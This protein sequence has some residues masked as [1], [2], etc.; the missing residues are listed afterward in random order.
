MKTM[1]MTAVLLGLFVIAGCG[2]TPKLEIETFEVN[3][4]DQ[5]RL[6]QLIEPYIFYG[7]EGTDG[8]Y[9]LSGN[10]LTVRETPDN[11]ARIT[12]VLRMYDVRKP[13]IMLHID[14][15][16][17]D[18]GDIDPSIQDIADRLRELF[19]F[20][21]YTKV[22]GGI[23]SVTE[24][25]S[26]EQTMGASSESERGSFHFSARFGRLADE[27]GQWTLFAESLDLRRRDGTTI[28]TSA[29][30]RTGQTTLVGTSLEGPGAKA[31][32]LAVRPEI[33]E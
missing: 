13:E 28:S 16:E 12:D 32:I 25:G 10:I 21:G 30:L 5:H 17:A 19:R 27:D 3:N 2:R 14:I 9:T 20:T 26:V 18:G 15:I 23:I 11:L 31:V 24:G 8:M 33:H 1:R 6:S 29:L 7:R 4:L 22:A